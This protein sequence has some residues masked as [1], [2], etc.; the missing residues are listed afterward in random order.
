MLRIA[1]SFV[2][3]LVVKFVNVP[4]AEHFRV[5][6]LLLI[7]TLGTSLR[8]LFTNLKC[9]K[10]KIMIFFDCKNAKSCHLQKKSQ[11]TFKHILDA[12]EI[13][14]FSVTRTACS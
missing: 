2:E 7:M 6:K 5:R 1:L 11:F 10:T 14:L 13:P 12:T 3:N 9:L 8:F 4:T